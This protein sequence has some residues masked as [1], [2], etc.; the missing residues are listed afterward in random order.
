MSQIVTTRT[1]DE[2]KQAAEHVKGEWV[3][4]AESAA[5]LPAEGSGGPIERA[6]MEAMLVHARCLI[7]FCC[8]GYGGK[9]DRRDIVPEDFMGVD[10][11]PHDEQF[12]RRLRGRIQFIDWNLQRTDAWPSEPRRQAASV[13]PSAASCRSPAAKRC[14]EELRAKAS[15]WVA[16]FEV[17]ELLV[18]ECCRTKVPSR[19]RRTWRQRGRTQRHPRSA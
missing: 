7:H 4:L 1:A 18:E 3:L 16:T 12:D 14:A 10:W 17:Q 5:M 2:L 8:G 15:A 6:A 13:T 19:P 9:R 11:W